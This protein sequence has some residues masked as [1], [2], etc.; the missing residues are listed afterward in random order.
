MQLAINVTGLQ[1]STVHEL[2][3]LVLNLPAEGNIS[4]DYRKNKNINMCQ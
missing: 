1:P 2:D 4:M 3:N